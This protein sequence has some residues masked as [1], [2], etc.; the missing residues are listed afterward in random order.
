MLIGIEDDGRVTGAWPRHGAATDPD[1]LAALIGSRTRPPL[2][3]QVEC[4]TLDGKPVLVIEIPPQRQAVATSDGVFLRRML[5]VDEEHLAA[6]HFQWQ[7]E[8]IEITSP[9]GFPEG[10]RLELVGT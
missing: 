7:S 10:V 5:G 8:Q 2:T 3:V 4:A 1:W 9:G 6:V